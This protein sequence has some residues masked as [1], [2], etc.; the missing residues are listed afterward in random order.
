[1]QHQDEQLS[2]PPPPP[3]PSPGLSARCEAGPYTDLGHALCVRA[4]QLSQP[5]ERDGFL[6]HFGQFEM[7]VGYVCTCVPFQTS[8]SSCA[9]AQE[10]IIETEELPSPIPEAHPFDPS[11]EPPPSTSHRK[12]YSLADLPTM[13]SLDFISWLEDRLLNENST[14]H[15]HPH[16]ALFHPPPS[17][18]EPDGSH[19]CPSSDQVTDV[20]WCYAQQYASPAHVFPC[21]AVLTST[22]VIVER[23]WGK[24]ES[25][26]FAGVPELSPCIILPL[27]SV[28]QAVVGPCHAYLR[29]EEAFVGKGGLFTL[30]AT[31]TGALKHFAKSLTDCCARLNASS[32]LD[33][34]DLS[35][36][37]DLLTELCRREEGLG[38]PSNRLAFTL[39]VKVREGQEVNPCLLVLSENLVYCL[40]SNCVYWPPA[41]FQSVYE[42]G[43]HLRV[44]REF[45]IMDHIADLSLH[46]HHAST[47]THHSS[48]LDFASVSL[49]MQVQISDHHQEELV[50]LFSACSARDTFLDR[51]TNLR[52][53]HAHR[54]SPS[55]REAPEGGNESLDTTDDGL[56]S[57]HS[58]AAISVREEEGVKRGGGSRPTPPKVT[59]SYPASFLPSS[60]DWKGYYFEE[61]DSL[62]K[63]NFPARDRSSSKA[64]DASCELD[65]QVQPDAE[66]AESKDHLSDIQSSGEVEEG[67]PPTAFEQELRQAVRSGDLLQP[68]P[69]R[70]RPV[71]L[72][73]GREVLNFFHSKIAG[74]PSTV[75]SSSSSSSEAGVKGVGAATL[76]VEGLVGEELLHVMWTSVVPYTDP[77]KELVT[78]CMLSTR[79]VYLVSD[80]STSTSSSTPRPSWMTH[81][82]HQSDSAVGWHSQ[83]SGSAGGQGSGR[84]SKVKPYAVL[85][86][87]DLVQ[88]SMGLF[89]QFLRLTGPTA[90]TIYTL[91]TRDCTR[92]AAFADK[93]KTSL[94]LFVSSPLGDKS[95]TDIEQDFYQAFSKRTFSTVESSRVG[96]VYPGDDAIED[97]L[98]LVKAKV[99]A[100]MMKEGGNGSKPS[101]AVSDQR[102]EEAM[103][104]YILAYQLL[105]PFTE[106]VSAVPPER[107]QARS[108]IITSHHI[109]LA[110]EDI[111]TYPLPDFVRGLPEQPQY[112]I[113]ET[114]RLESLKRVLLS[115]SNPHV[116]TLVFWDEPEELVVD[117]DM[118]HFGGVPVGER[119]GGGKGRKKIVPE[120]VLKL[121][122]QSLRDSDKLVKTLEKQW[123][124]LVPQVGRILDVVRE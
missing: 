3:L 107:I 79:A 44:V 28:Q 47:G 113:L 5:G 118:E 31:D 20:M 80:S 98:F 19:P 74:S 61:A 75:A 17:S 111:V 85:A 103:W 105:P 114:R 13:S 87:S 1:M 9:S 39:M 64:E 68:I 26:S 24:G 45:S 37:S 119:R 77:G 42:E 35:L 14:P 65:P 96:F 86:L 4:Q 81:N 48:K 21:C 94:A 123:R 78:L 41:T 110:R 36:Q 8:V 32:P 22:K 58:T 88:V 38:L 33:V 102:K 66:E 124:Q 76:G 27:G 116:L 112:E 25:S 55:E 100:L 53:E 99:Q 70:L 109:C 67:E 120:V 6:C 62:A 50:F 84:W 82:R 117:T 40:D 121:Y 91:A 43:I 7:V 60:F 115:A 2:P 89:D 10:M 108:I 18:E 92:S 16:P 93:L 49:V 63:T 56:Q 72:M 23:L 29:L 95:P 30:F 11:S 34:L 59:I 12:E 90:H 73:S 52:A 101:S 104:L 51:L 71:C 69:A 46:N 54:M 57:A 122:V 106:S 83:G 97:I 15:P